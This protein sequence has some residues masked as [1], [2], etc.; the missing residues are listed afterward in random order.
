MEAANSVTL[1]GGLGIESNCLTI[2][3][4]SCVEGPWIWSEGPGIFAH[5]VN[6]IPMTA[7][8]RNIFNLAANPE[9]VEGQDYE[10]YCPINL[11]NEG[12]VNKN[13]PDYFVAMKKCQ[14]ASEKGG[15][16]TTKTLEQQFSGTLSNKDQRKTA[17]GHPTFKKTIQRTLN[18]AET[19]IKNRLKLGE[20]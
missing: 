5:Y 7:S 16:R 17:F 6:C 1:S 3:G 8:G 15:C 11:D 2:E 4:E 13:S 9:A 19:R 20:F 12:R 10:F 18:T 14:L